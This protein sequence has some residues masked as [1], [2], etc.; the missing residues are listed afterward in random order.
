MTTNRLQAFS[1]G[2]FAVA[3]TLLVFNLTVPNAASGHLW[4]A[5]RDEWPY[6]ASYLVSFFVIGIIWVNHHTIFDRIARVDRPLLFL[7]LVLLVWVVLIPFP[8]QLLAK[9][10]QS[11]SDSHVAAA[12]YS[13]TMFL[14]SVAFSA[15]WSY[16]V[17]SHDLLDERIDPRVARSALPRFASGVAIYAV[18]IGVA[19]VNAVVCLALHAV[20]ALYYVFD[21]ISTSDSPAAG[22]QDLPQPDQIRSPGAE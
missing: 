10:I 18:T 11:G 7:N 13:G 15:L 12:A 19:F 5:L 20:I 16:A 1:D 8:T 6:F 22:A 21:Q 2:V 9:Y 17:F 14:M 3:I 4:R